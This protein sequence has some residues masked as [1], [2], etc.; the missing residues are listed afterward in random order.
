MVS[1]L[2]ICP[3]FAKSFAKSRIKT[4]FIKT[5]MKIKFD[6]GDDNVLLSELYVY[7]CL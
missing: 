7:L 6:I 1:N 4:N 2:L 5:W 3:S